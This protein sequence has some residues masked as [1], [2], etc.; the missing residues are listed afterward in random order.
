MISDGLQV[1]CPG[2]GDDVERDHETIRNGW[3]EL[4]NRVVNQTEHEALVEHW[5]NCPAQRE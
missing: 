5:Q 4:M 3:G 1:V 2:C